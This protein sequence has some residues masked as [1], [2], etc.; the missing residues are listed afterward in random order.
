MVRNLAYLALSLLVISLAVSGTNINVSAQQPSSTLLNGLVS[1]WNLNETTGNTAADFKNVSN[2]T[3]SNMAIV[4]GKFSKARQSTGTGFITVGNNDAYSSN[5][6][7]VAAWVN[8]ASFGQGN[9][10]SIYSRRTSL[11]KGMYL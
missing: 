9:Y 5:N 3:A 8:P 6:F 1:Y 10:A 4:D 11:N 7:T 2:G